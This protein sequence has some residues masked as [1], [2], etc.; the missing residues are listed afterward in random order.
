MS[1]DF[2]L[3]A[4]AGITGCVCAEVIRRVLVYRRRQN[5]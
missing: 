4:V 1:L 5:K 2:L 3:G